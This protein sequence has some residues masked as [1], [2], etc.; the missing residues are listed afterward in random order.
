M[1]IQV[2]EKVDTASVQTSARKAARLVDEIHN[3]YDGYNAAMLDRTTL[4][5]DLSEL[6]NKP[7]IYDD[8]YDSFAVKMMREMAGEGY[9]PGSTRRLMD[10]EIAQAMSVKPEG[11]LLEPGD[12]DVMQRNTRS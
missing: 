7:Q 5:M 9:H 11:E 10:E 1:M 12:E 4:P 2:Q 3:M 6:S 8:G